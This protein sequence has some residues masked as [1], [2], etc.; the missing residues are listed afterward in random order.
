MLLRLGE[1]C[2]IDSL[3]NILLEHL[4]QSV[5][6]LLQ[7]VRVEVERLLRRK[8][9]EILA[10]HFANVSAVIVYYCLRVFVNQAW[11]RVRAFKIRK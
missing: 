8:L 11:H 3:H 4:I 9:I 7:V 10:Q 5:Y 2:Q 6:L 1:A